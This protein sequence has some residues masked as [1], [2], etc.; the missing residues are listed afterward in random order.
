MAEGYNSYTKWSMQHLSGPAW[1]A[2]EL[3]QLQE[4]IARLHRLLEVIT[5]IGEPHE[6]TPGTH[7]GAPQPCS[8]DAHGASHPSRRAILASQEQAPENVR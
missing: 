2:R 6:E 3:A 1:Y 8:S 5:P 4:E 7:A